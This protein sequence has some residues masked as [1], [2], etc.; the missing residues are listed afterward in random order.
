MKHDLIMVLLVIWQLA[1]FC[2]RAVLAAWVAAMLGGILALAT[3]T[4][5]TAKRRKAGRLPE[6]ATA[7]SGQACMTPD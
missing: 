6:P 5:V 3:C 4:A 2:V 7:R 1:G